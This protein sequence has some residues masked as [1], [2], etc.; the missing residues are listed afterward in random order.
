[1][2][3]S[4]IPEHHLPQKISIPSTSRIIHLFGFGNSNELT[5]HLSIG[6]NSISLN[7]STDNTTA[8]GFQAHTRIIGIPNTTLVCRGGVV[9]FDRLSTDSK[10]SIYSRELL[11]KAKTV[12]FETGDLADT[13]ALVVNA[14]SQGSIQVSCNGSE[15]EGD[16]IKID[17]GG[18]TAMIWN[19][20]ISESLTQKIV[21]SAQSVGAIH[22]LMLMKG[23]PENW[24]ESFQTKHWDTIVEEGAL[25]NS[26]SSTI[27][28]KLVNFEEKEVQTNAR[29]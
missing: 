15:I 17:N 12:T 23:G 24:K 25:S 16:P 28:M 26:G 6:P 2:S 9:S 14:E 22:S 10:N 20:P 29:R 1:M 13:L 19:T 18:L 8:I 4:E 11:K 7:C 5:D 27:K 21:A 3:S